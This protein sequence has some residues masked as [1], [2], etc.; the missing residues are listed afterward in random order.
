MARL[1][2]RLIGVGNM[3][4]PMALRMLEQGLDLVV[5]DRNPG[6]ETALRDLGATVAL[7]WCE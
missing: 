5:C 2:A 7:E 4:H 3:G 1:K 6:A